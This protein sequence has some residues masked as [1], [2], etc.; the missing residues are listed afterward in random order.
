[1]SA[2]DLSAIMDGLAARGIAYGIPNAYGY[3]VESVTVPCLLV[4]FP[5]TIELS[6]TF[7]RGG[8]H[9]VLSV[10]HLVGQSFTKDSR[11]A[12]SLAI[13]GGADLVDAIE[14]AYSWGDVDVVKAEVSTVTIASSTYLG[15]KLT[16]DVVT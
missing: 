14:G 1:M 6:E 3:P 13:Q 15:I 10:W 7:Q 9:V 8:D 5:D 12:L 16:V 11:D 4:D 2:A